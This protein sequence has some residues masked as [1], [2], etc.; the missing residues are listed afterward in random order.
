[1]LLLEKLQIHAQHRLPSADRLACDNVVMLI[2]SIDLMGGRIV[3]LVQGEKLKLAFDDFEYWLDRFSKYPL[4]QLID[5]DAAM[6]QGENRALIEM[7]C[8]RLPCQVG[9]G[10]KEAADGQRLLD[11]GA[12]RVI[13]GSSLFG[14]DDAAR[15]HKIIKLEFA[16]S[17]KA[18]LGEE[19]LCFSVDTKGGRVAVRGW[20]EQVEL[21]PEE[22]VT[23]LEDSCAAF[24]YTH[25]DTEGTM[26]GFPIDVA[27]VL[28]ACTAKQLIV[29]GGIKER[30]EVDEL[31]AMGVDAV[32]GMAVY[33]G[34]MEA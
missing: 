1:L 10:L 24:L 31:D 34:A 21:T 33:T 22:A 13:Y 32:A 17:L 12:K 14:A 27:A 25:V 19:A 26:S 5:L 18:A 2:P 15:R 8:K 7:I 23:W 29:A 4:V 6:R 9:G 28:R 20:K 11:V 16:E 3:Q 30:K